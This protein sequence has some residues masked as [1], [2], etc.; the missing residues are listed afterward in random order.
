MRFL[1]VAGARPQ[2][3]KLAALHRPLTARGHEHFIVHTGQHYDHALSGLFF[4]EF[5]LPEPDINLNVGSQSQG[6]QTAA[7]LAGIEDAVL[8][9]KPDWVLVYG[10]TNSTL[11]G[12]LATV[13]LHVPLAHVEAGARSYNRWMSEEVNRVIVDHIADALFTVDAPDAGHLLQEGIPAAKVLETG[14]VMYD[15]ALHF[16]P[17]AAD[18]AAIC[19]QQGVTPGQYVL[20]TVHRAE[21][22]DFPERLRAIFLGFARVAETL[23]VIL[24]L[25]P[26]TRHILP[27]VGLG[28]AELGRLRLVDPV[29]FRESLALGSQAAVIAT[30]SGGMQ[31]EAYY[32]RV[33]GVILRDDTESWPLLEYGWNVLC[34]PQSPQQVAETVLGSVGRRGQ[35][36]DLYGGGHAGERIVAALEAREAVRQCQT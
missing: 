16:R 28:E 32:H 17:S 23:D 29:G 8:E 31:R 3:V 27:T 21:N 4:E 22:T 1:S 20:A 7:A 14:D 30:D 13:K 33:P 15:S 6:K 2:F 36:V 18:T 26:R 24:P 35:E 12:A 5:G 11:A 10:D 25:H 9:A 19:A 34:S